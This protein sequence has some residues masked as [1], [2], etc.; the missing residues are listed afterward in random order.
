MPAHRAARRTRRT[1]AAALGGLTLL[2]VFGPGAGIALAA[3]PG[4]K[5][6]GDFT[7]QEDAQ[8]VYDADPSDPNGLDGSDDDGRVCESLPHRSSAITDIGH[9]DEPTHPSG[10]SSS[11]SG[12]SSVTSHATAGTGARRSSTTRDR[13]CA[14]FS[15]RAE[16]QAVLDADPSDPERLDADDDGL[17]CESFDFG[18]DVDV[19][20]AVTSSTG[21]A[22]ESTAPAHEAASGY[23]VGGVDAGDGSAPSDGSDVLTYGLLGTAAA[24]G[25]VAARHALPG[26]RHRRA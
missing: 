8:A 6:C 20:S 21:S 3:G 23:P 26:G 13:D 11:P 16:A 17:A 18:D 7:Y 10:S 12:S 5:N 22:R 25:A 19:R 24:A 4:D 2:S 1:R 9:V 14:D 15:S